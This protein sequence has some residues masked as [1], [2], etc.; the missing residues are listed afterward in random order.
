MSHIWKS[1]VAQMNESCCISKMAERVF[2]THDGV[3]N[4]SCHTCE[5]VMSHMWMGQVTHMNESCH[6][7]EWVKSHIW[8]SHVAYTNESCCIG[9]M[10]NTTGL[11]CVAVCCSVLQC[12]AVCCSV[13]QR[14]VACRSV[15]QSVDTIIHTHSTK[16]K[17]PLLLCHMIHRSI[18][19][20]KCNIYTQNIF[21]VLILQ[22]IHTLPNTWTTTMYSKLWC[23]NDDSYFHTSYII[24]KDISS[25]DTLIYTHSTE[26]INDNDAQH[27]MM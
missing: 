5:W 15:L 10:T 26:Y 27:V 18:I 3:L 11:M 25:I 7:C 4:E 24:A 17:N 21:Q 23:Q 22:H 1:H 14:V 16:Y 19:W 20:M 2:R 9:R 13:V 12:G 6:T 8:M